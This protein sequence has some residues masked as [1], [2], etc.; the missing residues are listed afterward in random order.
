[1]LGLAKRLKCKI[2]QASISET[3]RD[4]AIH[5]QTEKYWGNVHSIE[6]RSC[7]EEVCSEEVSRTFLQPF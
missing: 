7:D 4:P 5:P 1:M 6:L 2:F 3:Y